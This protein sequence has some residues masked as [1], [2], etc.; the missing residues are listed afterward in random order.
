MIYDCFPFNNE[1]M[2]LEIRLNHH[3]PFVDKF[4]ISEAMF[5]YSGLPKR[6]YY[7][8]VKNRAPF[9]K[10]K[11]KIIHRVYRKL[12]PDRKND[13]DIEHDQRN[14]LLLDMMPIFKDDDLILYLDCDEMIRDGK[15]IDEAM[16]L[17]CIITLEMKFCWYYFN[18]I[19]KPGSA[20]QN[21]YSMEPC[22]KHRW[23]MGKI[24]R[25]KHLGQ[26][27]NLYELRQYFLWNLGASQA[28]FD[29]GW[30]F[31]NLG[32]STF[33]HDKF[34]AYPTDAELRGQYDI[35]PELIQSRKMRLM[36]PLGRDVSF[37][38]TEL[39][40]PQFIID[41]IGRYQE[42]ILDVSNNQRP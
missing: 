26:F 40:V 39:D 32:D 41:N 8:E 10:F 6:L 38:Q 35:S 11:D 28:I 34:M 27:N 15:V 36:D 33:I 3:A 30:H 9:V 23:H 37:I 17:D 7:N 29:S 42:Y 19:I 18:C 25:K 13:W 31:S 21:G 5:T 4:V 2:L 14:S 1:L 22:F 12:P 20:Y 16:G 24:C